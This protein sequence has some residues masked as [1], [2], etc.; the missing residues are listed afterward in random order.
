M[1]SGPWGRR[2]IGNTRPKRSGSSSQR[3]AI[4]GVNDEVAQVSMTSGSPAKPPGTPRRDSS[5]PGGASVVGS[6]GRSARS[7]R[8]GCS[9]SSSPS[10]SIGYHTGTDTPKNLCLEISQSP[11]SPSTQCLKRTPMKSGTQ[12]SSSP[13]PRSAWRSSSSRPPLRMYHCRLE[14]IS[15]GR[16]P[17]SKNFTGWV[18]GRGSPSRS[19][20]SANNSAILRWA[21]LG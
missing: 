20:A 19:P 9:K 14:M 10:L 18:I 6:T 13:L 17:F 11:L 7:G 3:P 4:C 2:S 15:R 1:I 16:S 8:I 21:W 12:S 5:Y